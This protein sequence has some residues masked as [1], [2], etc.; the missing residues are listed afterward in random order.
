M[1][2]A[3]K[4]ARVTAAGL[5]PQAACFVPVDCERDD[6]VEELEAAGFDPTAPCVVTWLGVTMY[7]SQAA[8]GATFASAGSA[9]AR[10]GAG[11]GVRLDRAAARPGKPRVCQG[12]NR[13]RR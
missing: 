12:H 7:L 13:R 1:T 3:N 8:I 5:D 6:L 4:V 2:Q 10:V 9:D 11:G